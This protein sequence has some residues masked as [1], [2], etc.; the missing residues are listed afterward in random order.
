VS[1]IVSVVLLKA[2]V[3]AATTT[4]CGEFEPDN[5]AAVAILCCSATAET[6]TGGGTDGI[7]TTM[8]PP[9]PQRRR[10]TRRGS[11]EMQRLS[12]AFYVDLWGVDPEGG[13]II[14]SDVRNDF[15]RQQNKNGST[16]VNDPR[17]CSDTLI[18]DHGRTWSE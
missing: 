10:A 3:P 5:A 16:N 9:P 13:E 1:A 15:Q 8:L 2:Y 7:A 12:I 14:T 4:V 17:F 11:I 18:I 6:P